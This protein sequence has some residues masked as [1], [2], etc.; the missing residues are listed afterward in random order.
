ML[1]RISGH[2]RTWFGSSVVR[3]L[4]LAEKHG[5]GTQIQQK[6]FIAVHSQGAN[7]ASFADVGFSVYSE[8][9][10]DGILLFLF[11]RIGCGSRTVVEVG[12]GDGAQNNSTNL[13]VNHGWRGVLIDADP[14][15][16]ERARRLYA[17]LPSTKL[18]RPAVLCERVTPESVRSVVES[19]GIFAGA[20]DLLSV[21]IDSTDLWVT[22]ALVWMQ[23]RV[24]VVEI[25]ARWGIGMSRTMPRD[26]AEGPV[27]DPKLG[28]IF[29]GA[30]LTAFRKMLGRN[31]YRL[32][33][34]NRVATNVFF[35]RDDMGREEFPEISEQS[36]LELPRAVQI[37]EACAGR[38]GQ[39]AWVEY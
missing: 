5:P 16:C 31:G 25:N 27:F 20:V 14:L 2:L 32:I 33:G 10:E 6:V 12:C 17:G 8:F 13:L 24:I 28:M 34:S 19:A 22:E 23:P 26:G 7:G 39:Y 4:E 36:V 11:T 38:L 3:P 30:S 15:N 1:T 9:E 18:L 37:Q 21:D 29:G 35:M